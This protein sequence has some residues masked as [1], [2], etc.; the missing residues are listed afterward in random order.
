MQTTFHATFHDAPSPNITSQKL[1]NSKVYGIECTQTGNTRWSTKSLL[2]GL[3]TPTCFH[4]LN[5][6][7]SFNQPTVSP[8]QLN[9]RRN[10]NFLLGIWVTWAMK[11]ISSSQFHD[12]AWNYIL[13]NFYNLLQ[14]YY[15]GLGRPS[16]YFTISKYIYIYTYVVV[17]VTQH[18][19]HWS[20]ANWIQS[21]KK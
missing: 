19:W 4:L 2:N 17:R 14:F 7:A 8:I 5:L 18:W 15:H 1:K 16:V 6:L 12:A 13:F 11:L 21:G 9:C 10:S 3:G 20:V